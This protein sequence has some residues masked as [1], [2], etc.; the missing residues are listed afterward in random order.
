MGWSE[1]STYSNAALRREA[2]EL[3]H[4]SRAGVRVHLWIRCVCFVCADSDSNGR[5]G[6]ISDCFEL[7]ISRLLSDDGQ[8]GVSLLAADPSQLILNGRS[9]FRDGP[10]DE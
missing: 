4:Y 9:L 5:F 10:K 3:P 6:D 2:A 7:Q 1:S 8:G